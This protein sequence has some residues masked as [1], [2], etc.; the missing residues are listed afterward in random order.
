MSRQVFDFGAGPVPAHQ[1]ANGGGW[2]ADT[3]QVDAGAYVG[4]SA[5]VSGEARVFGKARVFGEAQVSG[6]AQ[7]SGE[8]RVS[9]KARVFGEAQV[10]GEARVFGEAQVSGEA[11]VFG[12]AQVSGEA[13]VKRSCH[14]VQCGP[15]GSRD[16]ILTLYRTA[17]GG[18]GASTGCFSGSVDDLLARAGAKGTGAHYAALVPV[19]AAYL[20]GRI[21]EVGEAEA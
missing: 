17:G 7:V 3:A 21:A 11:R 8:A 20:A 16:A 9:G 19:L 2:V 1:H 5:Q 13:Q 15:M 4:H 10:S 14:V 12:E 18:M 6:K